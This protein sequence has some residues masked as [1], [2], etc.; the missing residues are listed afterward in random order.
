MEKLNLIKNYD[1]NYYLHSEKEYARL[2][3][4]IS[5]MPNYA[6]SNTQNLSH[7]DVFYETPDNLLKRL[8][9]SIRV[10]HEGDQQYLS[11]VCKNNG[12]K[13]EFEMQMK[14]G[15]KI[16]D[17]IEYLIFL[18]DKL[19]DIY[20]HNIDANIIRL[21]K[22]LKPFLFITTTRTRYEIINNTG[23]KVFVDFDRTNFKTKRHDEND[24]IV[25]IKLKSLADK[26]NLT[27]YDRFIAELKEK[28]LLLPMEETKYDAGMRV[29]RY[30]Y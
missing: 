17:K 6:I 10:R 28:V 27:A 5:L 22:F 21:L 26:Q 29:F 8:D 2:Y 15:D 23:L 18:E 30:E 14:F 4:L 13:R 19:Q 24:N 9:A 11:I 12:V 20:T 3:E 16:A 7:T 25:E 1:E